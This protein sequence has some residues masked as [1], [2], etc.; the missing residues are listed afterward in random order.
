MLAAWS[1]LGY[2]R[3][4]RM[5]HAA[6]KK[7]VAATQ[8]RV[9]FERTGIACVS[10]HWPLHSRGHCQHRF[11]RTGS[12]GGWK[13]GESIGAY[14]GQ[15]PGRR[16]VWLA[17]GGP[18]QSSKARRLQP[19]DDGA[20]SDGMFAEATEMPDVSGVRDVRQPRGDGKVRRKPQQKKREI[21]Y[22]IVTPQRSGISSAASARRSR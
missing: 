9:S 8:R 11:R 21:Q 6:A 7:I 3:R 12:R 13:C 2:Y 10:R 20:G 19:G 1:G 5:L 15:K 14:A 4:A 17:S 18:A 22:A 16:G